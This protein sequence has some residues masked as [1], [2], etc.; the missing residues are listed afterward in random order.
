[1][2]SRK[3]GWALGADHQTVYRTTNG[4]TW[5]ATAGRHI[6]PN[7]RWTVLQALSA[8]EAWYAFAASGSAIGLYHTTDG[9]KHWT[10]H[11]V[12]FDYIPGLRGSDPL[13]GP[14]SISFANPDD[15]WLMVAPEHG[16]STQP[17]VLYRTRD[18]G[19][20]WQVV[21][22][23]YASGG[24]PSLPFSGDISFPGTR[25]GWLVG[26]QTS[27][28]PRSLYRTTD[29]GSHWSKVAFRLPSGFDD[30]KWASVVAPP[31]FAG[32]RGAMTVT[33][34]GASGRAAWIYTSTDGG[35][36]WHYLDGEDY[37][38]APPVVDIVA[39]APHVVQFSFQPDNRLVVLLTG[40]AFADGGSGL[41][42]TNAGLLPRRY[43]GAGAEVSEL[44]F[45]D[46]RYGWAI[47][48]DPAVAS[49]PPVVLRTTDG[50]KEWSRI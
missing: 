37:T 34:S 19:T 4:V 10:Y 7:R 47:I 24:E 1:M 21:A 41:L 14:V 11:A 9:G 40:F 2:L 44:D 6:A 31:V 17:G 12:R 22:S 5:T 45:A 35:T 32:E 30:N 23:T 49:Q 43:L 46:R 27:T 36:A 26:S 20:T 8:S 3:F 39:V 33:L 28:S 42:S 48:T 50:G 29:G 16:M 13:G 25:S 18:G 15:G 38:M